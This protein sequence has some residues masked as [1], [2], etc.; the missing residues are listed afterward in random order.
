[1]AM[2]FIY[3]LYVAP[4][5]HFIRYNN[6][7]HSYISDCMDHK[8]KTIYYM[9]FYEEFC[10]FHPRFGHSNKTLRRVDVNCLKVSSWNL[11]PVLCSTKYT[12]EQN[13]QLLEL[14]ATSFYPIPLF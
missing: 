2:P 4:L 8:T 5:F 1:M 10:W 3:A 7:L 6:Q 14:K 9:S 12:T 11:S 13:Y